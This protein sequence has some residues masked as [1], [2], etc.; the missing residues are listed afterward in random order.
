MAE[1]VK[2]IPSLA[3]IIAEINKKA[4]ENVLGFITETSNPEIKRL[5]TGV[6]SLDKALGGGLPAGRIVEFFGQPSAGKSL[7]ALLTIAQAQK[8]GKTCIYLDSEDSFDVNWAQKL[9]VDTSKLILSQSSIGEDTMELIIKL[10]DAKPD[11]IVLDSIAAMVTRAELENDLDKAQMA[12]KARLMSKALRIIMSQNKGTTI[13]F[14]N[15]IRS[16]MALYGPLWTVPG[17]IAAKFAASV[18]VEIK[19]TEELHEDDKKTKPVIGQIVAFK[20]VKNKT[21]PPFLTG[22]FKFFF[23]GRVV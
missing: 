11:I 13:I 4:G 5:S 20:V 12:P 9:G 14:I 10:L 1:E 7:I 3:R 23:D 2:K 15:Q 17:G 6:S 18:R 19:K 8:E 16:T 22:S 21:A